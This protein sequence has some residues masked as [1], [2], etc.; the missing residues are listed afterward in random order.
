MYLTGIERHRIAPPELQRFLREE[1]GRNPH[2]EPNFRLVWG[3]SRLT[4]RH[5]KWR[6]T[7]PDTGAFL[8]EVIEAREVPKYGY[9]LERWH[10]EVWHPAEWYGDPETWPVEWVNGKSCET[11]GEFPARGGYESVDVLEMW[12]RCSCPRNAAQC[13]DCKNPKKTVAFEP[14]RAYLEHFIRVY[15]LAQAATA[16]EIE[17]A[18]ATQRA[19]EKQDSIDH[20]FEELTEASRPFGPMGEYVS[21]AGLHVPRSSV[22]GRSTADVPAPAAEEGVN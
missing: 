15:R 11:L 17:S 6:D 16:A 21:Y 12:E 8:R 1:G 5:G 19:K 7:D 9:A 14:S 13:P 18:L 4:W 22:E 10:I 20:Y 2:N 3:A